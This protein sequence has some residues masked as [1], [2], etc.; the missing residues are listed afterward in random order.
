MQIVIDNIIGSCFMPKLFDMM[1]SR[2]EIEQFAI[3]EEQEG[4][5]NDAEC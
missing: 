1:H 5:H 4:L 3:V 2:E